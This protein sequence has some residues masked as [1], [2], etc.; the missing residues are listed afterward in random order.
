MVQGGKGGRH[1][2]SHDA[3]AA[4]GAL[5][6]EMGAVRFRPRARVWR[7]GTS[8]RGTG[9]PGMAVRRWRTPS[10]D[11]VRRGGTGGDGERQDE[12]GHAR[13]LSCYPP[14]AR[15]SPPIAREDLRIAI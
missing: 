6:W 8:S 7:R 5:F 12:A 9:W 13:E 15:G 11:R 10:R 3:P 14:A 2:R 1:C 4:C